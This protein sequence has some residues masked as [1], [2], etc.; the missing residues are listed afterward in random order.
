MEKEVKEKYDVLI[1]AD[2]ELFIFDIGTNQHVSAHTFLPG[3]K[4][5]PA[6]VP[7]GAIQVDGVAAEF[8]IEPASTQREWKEN[9]FHVRRI[10]KLI[11]EKHNKNYVLTATPSVMFD[12]AYFE[13]LPHSVKLLGCEPDFDAYTGKVNPKPVTDFP[14]RTGSGHL[15]IGWTNNENTQDET[16]LQKCAAMVREFDFA[17]GHASKTWDKDERRRTLYGAPGSFR[18]KPYGF[19]YRPLSNAWLNDDWSIEF[20]YDMAKGLANRLLKGWSLIEAAQKAKVKIDD[21]Y[22]KIGDFMWRNNLPAIDEYCPSLETV[23]TQRLKEAR[24]AL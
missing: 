11:T 19:E 12:Q 9:I 5:D 2:P 10:L 16:Y 24:L 7:K 21:N 1:G 17:F 13:A 8:N 18:P 15:H 22:F 6:E 23:N 14:M 3:T 4:T 20:V